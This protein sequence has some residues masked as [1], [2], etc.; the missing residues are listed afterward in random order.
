M[1]CK[2]I[3]LFAASSLKVSRMAKYSA[4]M[5]LT[6]RVR[7]RDKHATVLNQ[8][9]RDVNLV[10]NWANE[11]SWKAW[12][13]SRRW[14]SAYD[15]EPWAAGASASLTLP[16]NTI[17]AVIQ[18]HGRKRHQ[19]R[20]SKL[21]WRSNYR[22]LGWV[23]F[24]RRQARFRDGMVAAFGQRFQVWDSYGLGTYD[25]RAGSFSQDARGRWYFNVCV[26]VA[27]QPATGTGMVGVDL[28]L[29]A[30]ATYSDGTTFEPARFYRDLEPALAVAQRAHKKRRA[31]AIHAKIANRRKDA[32]HKET[33]RL[34]KS[35]ALI[36]V[37]NVSPSKIAKTRFAKSV[38]DRSWSTFTEQL[39]YK[40]IRHSTAFVLVE[41][42]FTTRTCSTCGARTGP[43][44]VNS[45]RVRE[46]TC[47]GCGDTHG[48]DVNAAKVILRLGQETPTGGA[49]VAA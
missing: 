31:V 39:R 26:E 38:L 18:E 44:G 35:Y 49:D 25:F 27:Q 17:L 3:D 41:E 22:S 15:I 6:L 20:R 13:E 23:P 4:Q 30:T 29:K 34:A 47:R 37:G 1:R 21:R 12:R 14:L 10:W 5:R 24:R 19:E 2:L 28:G 16:A 7:V 11:T 9:A 36:A 45:L 48:R 33:T 43:Q 32:L 40:A 8:M 46:W 42:A